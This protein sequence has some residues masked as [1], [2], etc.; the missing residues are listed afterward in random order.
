M[1]EIK[2]IGIVSLAKIQGALGAIIGFIVGLFFAAIGSA[3]WSSPGMAEAGMPPGMGAFFGV[4]AI[5]LLPIAYGIG[6]FIGGVITA[7][8]Y[9]VVAGVVGGIE[10]ELE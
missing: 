5:I 2:K 10:I 9:N 1:Q 8:L 3:F 4:A 7:F 6:G